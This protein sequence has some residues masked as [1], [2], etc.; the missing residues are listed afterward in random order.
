MSEEAV[1]T[2]LPAEVQAQLSQLCKS[3]QLMQYIIAGIFLRYRL[4]DLQREQ[5]LQSVC[6]PEQAAEAASTLPMEITSSLLILYALCGYFA[7]NQAFAA[8]ATDPVAKCSIEQDGLLSGIVILVAIF[9]F[10]KLLSGA[11]S[12]QATPLQEDSLEDTL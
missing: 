3:Q 6:C 2:D 8:E 9:R 7:Q 11:F 12:N 1:L 4:F 10:F 5:L